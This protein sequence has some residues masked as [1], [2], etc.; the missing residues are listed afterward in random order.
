LLAD[1][2]RSENNSKPLS[3]YRVNVGRTACAAGQ[4]EE[5]VSYGQSSSCDR[6][7]QRIKQTKWG[8]GD[9]LSAQ[10][11]RTW[12]DSLQSHEDTVSKQEESWRIQTST[13]EGPVHAASLQIRT[14][15]YHPTELTLEFED[16][17]ELIISEETQ[18]SPIVQIAEEAKEIVI[19][20]EAVHVDK[21]DDVLE[22]RAWQSLHQIGADSGWEAL[23]LRNSTQVVVA[24]LVPDKAAKLQIETAVAQAN[25][26]VKV[27]VRTYDAALPSDKQLIPERDLKGGGGGP[28]QDWLAQQFPNEEDRSAYRNRVSE[29]SRVLL[30]QTFVYDKLND[31]Y[32]ALRDC[33]CRK[34]LGPILQAHHDRIMSLQ[35]ELVLA[36]E[37]LMGTTPASTPSRPLTY[38]QAQELDTALRNTVFPRPEGFPTLEDGVEKL[39][40]LL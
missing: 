32:K 33:S 12:R 10:T 21:A 26:Q 17:E 15:D 20:P 25:P 4:G 34:S 30:G 14:S 22:V 28:G 13:E 16:E 39:R 29:L 8:R 7:L 38:L 1:A 35:N 18:P 37:P 24:G 23:V 27:E 19:R 40:S 11:F 31:R 36:L 3:F 5:L 6:A 9:P 2:I